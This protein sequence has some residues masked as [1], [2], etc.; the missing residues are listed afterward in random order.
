MLMA[1]AQLDR[2]KRRLGIVDALQDDL[3]NDL[4]DDAHAQFMAITDA[5]TVL[6]KYDFIISEV[7]ILRYNRKG[8]EG[9]KSESV[10]GYSVTYETDDFN[11]YMWLLKKDFGLDES[12]HRKKG[13]VKFI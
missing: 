13:V 1:D 5:D 12:K 8:S 4:I 2:I 3:I 6:P 10:D 7:V 9:M 11:A